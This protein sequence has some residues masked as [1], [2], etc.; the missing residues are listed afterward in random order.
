MAIY[1]LERDKP[2]K[3][4]KK[5]DPQDKKIY[6]LSYR[7][8]TWIATKEAIQAGTLYVPTVSNGLMYECVSGG[9]TGATEPTWG[10]VEDGLTDDGTAQ[11][12]AIPLDCLLAEGDTITLSTWAVP[13]DTVIDSEAIV[14]N[15]ITKFRLTEVPSGATSV[16]ITNHVTVLRDGG[17]SEEFDS[18]LIILVKS[19]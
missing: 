17:D 14:N 15:Q 2:F 10:T 5:H 13:T 8:V 18:T 16:E 6:S 3:V 11:F 12:K 9:I 1:Y 4:K 19:L 7:P